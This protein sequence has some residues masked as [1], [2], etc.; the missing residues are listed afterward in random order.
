MAPIHLILPQMPGM[1]AEILVAWL[2]SLPELELIAS[3]RVQ[4]IQWQKAVT[5]DTTD[6]IATIKAVKACL[7]EAE[8]VVVWAP[9]QSLL[10]L[11]GALSLAMPHPGKPVICFAALFPRPLCSSRIS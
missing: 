10:G 6:W 8:G 4:V 1:D 3:V 11:A 2:K 5:G 9:D 7:P